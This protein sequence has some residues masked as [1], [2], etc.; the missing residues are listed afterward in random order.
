MNS[1]IRIAFSF[2][3]HHY[4]VDKNICDSQIVNSDYNEQLQPTFQMFG[5]MNELEARAEA[6]ARDSISNCL[7]ASKFLMTM[8]QFWNNCDRDANT[9]TSVEMNTTQLEGI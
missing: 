4:P 3:N 5:G 9:F 2:K 7:C 1:I 6:R 8:L